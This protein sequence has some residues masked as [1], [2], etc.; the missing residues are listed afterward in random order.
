MKTFRVF[1]PVLAMMGM[2][3]AACSVRGGFAFTTLLSFTGTNGI[4]PGTSPECGLTLGADG[5]FYGTTSAGG[6]NNLGTI[7]RMSPDGAFTSVFS[8]NGTNGAKPCAALSKGSDN[9][10]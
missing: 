4:C 3:L 7:F 5:N 1:P 10:L 2:F 9:N 8:F 6:S